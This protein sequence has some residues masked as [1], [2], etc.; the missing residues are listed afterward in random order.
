MLAG[1]SDTTDALLYRDRYH[2][3]FR[4]DLRPPE[5]AADAPDHPD[6]D[7]S[8]AAAAA[9]AAVVPP[10][11]ATASGPLQGKPQQAAAEVPQRRTISAM[12]EEAA[13]A[14]PLAELARRV[15]VVQRPAQM[16]ALV[17][18]AHGDAPQGAAEGLTPCSP[19]A[20]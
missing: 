18:V 1:D 2:R 10:L 8:V 13:L 12:Q 6:H 4:F 11:P 16:R 17:S 7:T 15:T 5:T 14:F 3:S 19:F 20:M 9:A